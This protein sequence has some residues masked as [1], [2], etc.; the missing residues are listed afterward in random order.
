[1]RHPF[2]RTSL[3]ARPDDAAFHRLNL[4]R[5]ARFRCV[6]HAVRRAFGGRARR[7]AGP[8]T[9]RR[10]FAALARQT[11]RVH[12]A[13]RASWRRHCARR[14]D[15]AAV[16]A[17]ALDYALARWGSI[18]TRRSRRMRL[19]DAYSTLAPFPDVPAA[20]AALAPRPRWILSNGTLAM[21]EPLVGT[22][23]SRRALDGVLSVDAAGIYKP[24]PARLPARGRPVAPPDL[25]HRL[26][27]VERLGRDRR[28]GVRIHTVLDQSRRARRSTGMGRRPIASIATLVGAAAADLA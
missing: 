19:R 20:L 23:G 22:I 27:V 8:G 3:C 24:S 25:A 17:T 12:L 4:R 1:M 28:E 15:F 16:T 7:N 2:N 13:R 26:R 21:L 14:D 11:A 10:A 6:R 18:S 9:R 5:R